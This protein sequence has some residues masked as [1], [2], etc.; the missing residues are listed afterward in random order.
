MGRE[1][2][3]GNL[4]KR[5]RRTHS[6]AVKAERAKQYEVHPTQIT[7]WGSQR[8]ES[9]PEL[10]GGGRAGCEPAM[11]LKALHAKIGELTLRNDFCL[12]R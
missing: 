2:D 11:D 3:H 5:T 6:P 1:A 7:A 9:M 8:L 10:S 4:T 12:V